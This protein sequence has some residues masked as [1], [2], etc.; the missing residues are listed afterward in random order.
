MSQSADVANDTQSRFLKRILET[1]PFLCVSPST[2]RAYTYL[3]T[4][5]SIS[6]LSCHSKNTLFYL[7]LSLSKILFLSTQSAY[8]KKT[9]LLYIYLVCATVQKH[10]RCYKF[11]F[12]RWSQ[13]IK[14][15]W[16]K[17]VRHVH[18]WQRIAQRDTKKT[19]KS[20]LR[21]C[22][23][24]SAQ[25]C[26]G[27]TVK[28]WVCDWNILSL[29]CSNDLLSSHKYLLIELSLFSHYFFYNLVCHENQPM[30]IYL[31]IYTPI[32]L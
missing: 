31:F 5:N 16:L 23:D 24:F 19:S 2:T 13:T 20:I 17:K 3:K 6:C 11:I 8:L 12:S 7:S 27:G 14:T 18:N 15:E 32:S 30:C 29:L 9:T 1:R 10:Q 25:I 4:E 21:K 26:Q 28:K 22:E